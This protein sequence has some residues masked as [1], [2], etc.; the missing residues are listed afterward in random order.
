[1]ADDRRDGHA[2]PARK[3]A[4]HDQIA[5][6]AQ[7]ELDRLRHES[8]GALT[9]QE[10]RDREGLTEDDVMPVPDL[11][12]R[13]TPRNIALQLLGLILF[14]AVV[15]FLVDLMVDSWGALLAPR[16]ESAQ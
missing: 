16:V 10:L 7:A 15:W 6:D 11:D 8:G 2:Q 9:G 4:S 13:L 3:P 5:A 12:W 14:G 1:M